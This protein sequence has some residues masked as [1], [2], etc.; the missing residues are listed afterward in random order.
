MAGKAPKTVVLVDFGSRFAADL[1]RTITAAGAEVHRVKWDADVLEVSTGR[2]R[3]APA[4]A[5][6]RSFVP[7][8]RESRRCWRCHVGQ[9]DERDRARQ[10][11]VS[12]EDSLAQGAPR[13]ACVRVG[14]GACP[15][16]ELTLFEHRA[17]SLTVPVLGVCFGHQTIATVYG[18]E[19]YRG[20]HLAEMV[21][22]EVEVEGD[23][24]FRGIPP[25]S[26]FQEYHTEG[27]RVPP[28]FEVSAQHQH[29]SPPTR[30]ST[31]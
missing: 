24:L 2:R 27:V 29:P 22:V 8:G 1:V 17:Q 21:T 7:D 14:P 25:K 3:G 9:S 10:E 20:I 31:R 12:G 15:P 4:S 13:R 19:V 30:R 28:G 11:R 5:W 16:R 23:L 6:S 18:G 26:R